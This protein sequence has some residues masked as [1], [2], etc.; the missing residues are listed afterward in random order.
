MNRISVRVNQVEW[1][2]E[3]EVMPLV[4]V[5]IVRA[6]KT[7]QV[8]RGMREKRGDECNVSSVRV[9]KDYFLARVE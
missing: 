5:D 4:V 1:K 8:H 3:S 6:E 2:G 9:I 7:E